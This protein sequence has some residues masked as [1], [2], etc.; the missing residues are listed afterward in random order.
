MTGSTFTNVIRQEPL[1]QRIGQLWTPA[2][3]P[4]LVLFSKP[5]HFHLVW[6]KV[7]PTMCWVWKS[8]EKQ[9]FGVRSNHQL[10]AVE[11]C[12]HA[13]AFLSLWHVRGRPGNALDN[14][15]LPRCTHPNN[16]SASRLLFFNTTL[17]PR[18]S[19]TIAG[20]R[21]LLLNAKPVRISVSVKTCLSSSYFCFFSTA[22]ECSEDLHNCHAEANC[23]DT[24][25]SFNCTCRV[26]FS[27]NGT[28]CRDGK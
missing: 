5:K 18:N 3:S 21:A 9:R 2:T 6:N 25:G 15:G 20:R 28:F 27:G 7:F 23:T 12:M 19:E 24:R 1:S 8:E 16:N 22:N 13:I 4:F 17:Q 26:G 10:L 14:A 11:F